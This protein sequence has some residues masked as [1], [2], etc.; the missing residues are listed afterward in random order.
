MNS[1]EQQYLNLI[2]KILESGET[3]ETRNSKTISCFSEKLD[4]DISTSIPFITTKKL[5]WKTVIKELLW[6]LS[7]S[8]DNQKLLDQ[9]VKIWIGNSTRE[10]MDS[11]GFNDRQVNDLGPVYGHQWR[12]FNAVYI[13]E[14]TDYTNKGVDQIQEVLHLLKTD[15]M[16][17]RII[18]SAWNPSQ[19]REM[20]L[21]PCHM[22]CQ[23]YVSSNQELSC[24]MYQRSADVGL[25]LPFNIA[26]YAVL[27]YILGKLTNLKPKKLSIII[28]DAHIYENHIDTLKEQIIREP[29]L[30]PSL[31]INSKKEFSK[32]EDFEIDDFIL[33]NYNYH[34]TL[35]MEMIA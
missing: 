21:P 17:R 34:E 18:L 10:Y 16:S 9:N 19:I 20:N 15:P 2:K 13:D 25:G 27:T 35:K 6:F 26:S 22:F 7:G 8:T 24:Q 31:E 33:N 23:F 12:H 28:G 5:A 3:R 30:F 4:F 1:D 11:I 32:V 29:F 14:K